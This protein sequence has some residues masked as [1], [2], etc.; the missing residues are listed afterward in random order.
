M[1]LE[2][3]EMELEASAACEAE[4]SVGAERGGGGGV[5]WAGRVELLRAS[6]PGRQAED[7]SPRAAGAQGPSQ[8]DPSTAGVRPMP[9]G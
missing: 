3:S 9:I 1:E 4:W 7:K 8:R 6:A 5:V 2:A